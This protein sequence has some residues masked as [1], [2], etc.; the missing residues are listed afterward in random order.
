MRKSQKALLVNL[1]QTPPYFIVESVD[2]TI[3]GEP[4]PGHIQAAKPES[5]RQQPSENMPNNSDQ[6][7]SELTS[8][9]LLKLICSASTQNQKKS[10][11]NRCNQHKY[12]HKWLEVI[13]KKIVNPH[14]KPTFVKQVAV[15]V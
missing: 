4:S 2:E 3:P 1:I 6:L 13:L 12:H 5:T 14:L 8:P 15:A 10:D 7:E 11:T 9:D